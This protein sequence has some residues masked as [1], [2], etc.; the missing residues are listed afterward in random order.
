M[1]AS[2]APAPATVPTGNTF[3][4]H[5]SRNPVVQRLVGRFDAALS[6]LFTTAAPRSVLD[7]GCGE[8]MLSEAWAQVPG[9][10]RVVGVDLEDPRLQAAWRT[11]RRPNLFFKTARAEALPFGENEFDLVAAIE[12]LEHVGEPEQALREMARVSS[13]HILVSIPREPLWRLLNVLRGAYLGALGNTPG[14]LNH[15]SG[16]E[17]LRLLARYGEV[18][19]VR[20]PLPWTMALVRVA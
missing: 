10:G 20:S 18:V 3:D 13:R 2:P 15:W 17:L 4:K 8:G 1:S 12:S 5:A 14:H 6:D 16:P 19:A 9:T 11:R 7:V